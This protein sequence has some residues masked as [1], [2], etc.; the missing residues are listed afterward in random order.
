V[1]LDV[2]IALALG[3]DAW[4]MWPRS[5][6]SVTCSEWWPPTRLSVDCSRR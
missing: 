5:V 3:G 1:L 2:A 6:L 4:P